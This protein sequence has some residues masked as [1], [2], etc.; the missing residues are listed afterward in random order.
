[1]RVARRKTSAITLIE[2][3]VSV[4]LMAILSLA[5]SGAFRAG[6]DFERRQRATQGALT[7]SE[8]LE[9]RIRRALEGA[10]LATDTEDT[11]AYFLGTTEGDGTLGAD[12]VT[13]TTTAPSLSL[14]AQETTDDFETANENLGPLGGMA[15]ISLSTIAVGDAGQNTGLFERIQRPADGDSTQGGEESVLSDQVSQIGFEF[16]DGLDWVTEWDT[17]E[18]LPGRLPAAVRVSYILTDSPDITHRFVVAIPGSDATADNPAQAEV[19][20]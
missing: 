4:V 14:A 11:S 2:L 15:E 5:I 16:F 3:L 1:M 9:G 20:Q 7:S 12:R 18:T 10:R 19:T 17:V 6:V 13:F 8:A